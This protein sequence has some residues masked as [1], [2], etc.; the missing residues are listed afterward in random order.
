MAKGQGLSE[1][2]LVIGLVSIV[3]IAA[4]GLLGQN[5]SGLL[6]GMI[7]H[8]NGSPSGT[9]TSASSTTP[10]LVANVPSAPVTPATP[11]VLDAGFAPMPGAADLELSVTMPD[12]SIRKTVIPNYPAEMANMPELIELSG[13]DGTTRRFAQ[14]LEAM[15]EQLVKDGVISNDQGDILREMSKR[16]FTIADGQRTLQKQWDKANATDGAM[17]HYGT[18]IPTY[19]KPPEELKALLQ[20]ARDKGALSNPAIKAIVEDATSKILQSSEATNKFALNMINDADNVQKLALFKVIGYSKSLNDM[21]QEKFEQSV[22]GSSS[23]CAASG[24]SR[25]EGLNCVAKSG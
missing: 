13:A 15:A 14:T 6:G 21:V 25:I 5:V 18:D 24:T 19:S 3:A 12:G 11:T 8:D 2:S 1:Y 17:E 22:Q 9:A 16:G 23:I 20:E 10:T 7:R 4:L